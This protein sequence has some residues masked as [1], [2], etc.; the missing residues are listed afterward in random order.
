MGHS[1]SFFEESKDLGGRK[2]TCV[3]R[4]DKS[5]EK[6]YHHTYRKAKTFKPV[7]AKVVHTESFHIFSLCEG[8]EVVPLI[9]KPV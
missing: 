9:F 6:A 3:C 8:N 7:M 5:Q 2:E 4:G 1:P